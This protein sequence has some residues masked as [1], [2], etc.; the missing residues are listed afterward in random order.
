[1]V[2]GPSAPQA[3]PDRREGPPIVTRVSVA[4]LV[5]G[6]FVGALVGAL[7]ADEPAT[8]PT[9]PDEELPQACIDAIDEARRELAA[10][11]EVRSVPD[12]LAALIERTVASATELDA[13]ALEEVLTDLERLAATAGAATLEVG[14][15]DFEE[16]AA[17]CDPAFEP[18]PTDAP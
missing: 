17:E 4:A 5:V 10:L 12:E 2:D 7:I 6:L 1:M 15:S 16:L 11:A 13:A 3:S 8:A 9:V 18:S 14:G